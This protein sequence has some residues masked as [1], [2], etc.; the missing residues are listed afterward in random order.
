V[1]TG[2][3]VVSGEE[4]VLEEEY[5]LNY[6]LGSI[7]GYKY[8]DVNGDGVL[9]E[10]EPGFEGVTVNLKQ[11]DTVIATTVTDAA[12]KFAFTD[13]PPGTYDI[14]EVLEAGV[15]TKHV[16]VITGV[17]VVS[18]EETVLEEE[19]FLNYELGSLSGL[20]YNDV[21]ANGVLDE[22]VDTPWDGTDIPIT[23]MLFKDGAQIDSDIIDSSDG[24]FEFS[25]LE[26]G[27]YE[28]TEIIPEGKD[29]KTKADTTLEVTVVSGENTEMAEVFLNYVEAAG[30]V[31]IE[32]V[33]T[34][35]V[36][37]ELPQ[38]GLN[39]LPLVLA[40]GLLTLLGLLALMLGL[41]RF[42]MT[43]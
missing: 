6:E 1:I 39:M 41:I 33:V 22:G 20:K 26:P 10:G 32:P 24:T 4:T 28:V 25:G 13:V 14:E 29:I 40:A 19:Y 36:Q 37:G 7:S 30:P 18:G 27:V 17:E 35:Q 23:V 11:G 34:P 16:T 38:T 9:D 31:I 8:T 12:G 3:E 2:V 21:N 42:R 15:Y 5:F 43:S